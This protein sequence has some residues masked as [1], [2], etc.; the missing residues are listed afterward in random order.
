MILYV[1]KNRI[2]ALAV[3]LILVLVTFGVVVREQRSYGKVRTIGNCVIEA[4][5][6]C[7]GA[8]LRFANLVG[9]DLTDSD[10]TG[11]DLTGANLTGAEFDN[12]NLNGI[13]AINATASGA[14]FLEATIDK[15]NFVGT[16]FTD[17]NFFEST[18]PDADLNG[19]ILCR[20]VLSSGN[21]AND[22][23]S[24]SST[25]K[26]GSSTAKPGSSTAK[27]GSPTAKPGSPTTKPGSP[28]TKPGSPTTKPVV[29][30]TKPVV[31]TTK[32][33]TAACTT[34]SV[35]QAY[36]SKW[37]TN[38]WPGTIEPTTPAKC[39]DG[40][41]S[42]TLTFSFIGESFNTFSVFKARGSS[43]EGRATGLSAHH[44]VVCNIG[45]HGQNVPPSVRAAIGCP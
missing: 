33:A 42:L 11:A 9:A 39:S 12:A 23:C 26:P 2:V 1:K 14:S 13:T 35:N 6:S 24:G 34:A 41:A 3:I 43:W 44:R 30:T 22:A 19:A 40:Y 17:A 27:P 45:L 10:L 32:P 38:L 16:N 18:I 8:N 28:T 31:T 5:T 20:T 21:I 15:A 37:P 25:T 36:L 4:G 7:P 29:T